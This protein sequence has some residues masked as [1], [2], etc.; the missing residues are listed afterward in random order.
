MKP[1]WR[2]SA[3]RLRSRRRRSLQSLQIG[4]DVLTVRRVGD[5][6]EHLRAMN[7]RGGIREE[8]IERVFVPREIRRLEGGRVAVAGLGPALAADDAGEGW[9]DLVFAGLCRMACGAA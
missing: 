6:D 9:T 2:S 4:D 5:A 8:L 1:M 7:V 3:S